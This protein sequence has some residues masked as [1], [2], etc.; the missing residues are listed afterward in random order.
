[1]VSQELTSANKSPIEIIGAMIIRLSGWGDD[2]AKREAR[3]IAYVTP[4]SETLYV[5][6]TALKSLGVI[7]KSFPRVGS[8]SS[9]MPVTSKPPARS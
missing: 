7:P 4:Q 6:R 2:G 3:E 8:C 5:S 1:M 9:K